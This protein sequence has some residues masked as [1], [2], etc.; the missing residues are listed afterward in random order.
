MAKIRVSQLLAEYNEL[1]D[2]AEL[3][4]RAYGSYEHWR[5]CQRKVFIRLRLVLC[6][7]RCRHDFIIGEEDSERIDPREQLC[8]VDDV[9]KLLED[10]PEGPGSRGAYSLRYA[11]K[12]SPLIKSP[13]RSL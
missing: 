4:Q 11:G 3:E 1:F 5:H 13:N 8:S 2:R 6:P 7:F 12:S 10:F 9:I